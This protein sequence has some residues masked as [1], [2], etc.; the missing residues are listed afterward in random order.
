MVSAISVFPPFRECGHMF[1]KAL[2]V[3]LLVQLAACAAPVRRYEVVYVDGP[4]PNEFVQYPYFGGSP[5]YPWASVDYFYLGNHYYRPYAPVSFSFG[6]YAGSPWY[7][8]W[9]APYYGPFYYSAWYPPYYSYPYFGP[10]FGGFGY[11][12]QTPYWRYPDYRRGH[13]DRHEGHDRSGWDHHG[14]YSREFSGGQQ[15]RTGYRQ[16]PGGRGPGPEPG[17]REREQTESPAP[18][19]TSR[20][21]SVA[22]SGGNSSPGMVIVNRRDRKMQPNRQHQSVDQGYRSAAAPQSPP[23]PQAVSQEARQGTDRYERRPE[24]IPERTGRTPDRAAP[25]DPG[26]SGDSGN[27][28]PPRNRD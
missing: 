21:V 17:T 15:R 1:K 8:P 16:D 26:G 3:L 6:F 28:K 7:G 11:G 2:S 19:Q 23:I 27:D 13:Y 18:L 5:Y 14:P 10:A 20:R 22:P 4:Y 25:D 12:W 24:R 9:Y